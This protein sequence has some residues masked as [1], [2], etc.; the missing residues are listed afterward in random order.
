M[1][2][3][4]LEMLYG[5]R[6][7]SSGL[8]AN[9]RKFIKHLKKRRAEGKPVVIVIDG[10]EQSVGKSMLGLSIC[11]DLDSHFTLEKVVYSAQEL[12]TGY[13]SR[14]PSMFQY[15]DVTGLLSKKG[16]RDDE[17]Q[18]LISAVSI[19]RKNGHGTIF[20]APKKE[21]LDGLILTGLAN[22]WIFCEDRGRA[23][24][25]RAYKGARYKRSQ[26][27]VPFDSWN[28]V[29][30]LGWRNMDGDP[31]FEAYNERAIERNRDYFRLR[32]LDPTGRVKECPRC[33][34]LGSAYII[35]THPCPG[36]P[37]SSG[38]QNPSGEGASYRPESPVPSSPPPTEWKCGA[39]TFYRKDHYDRHIRTAI[40]K[41]GR[42]GG[43]MAAPNA[44]AE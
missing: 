4:A 21:L 41:M 3:A 13:M 25:H 29:T 42:C 19:V 44:S 38:E 43:R 5:V 8:E 34:K 26:S 33:K 39:Y 17:M 14:T 23:R 7:Q 30:P 16:S 28:A 18:G 2:D 27:K 36:A 40:H 12:H 11:Q 6:P 15:D 37:P 20:I 1:S 9:Y 31:F 35:A 22:F 24:V 32:A 10:K